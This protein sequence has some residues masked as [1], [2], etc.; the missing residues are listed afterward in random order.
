MRRSS[1]SMSGWPEARHAARQAAPSGASTSLGQNAPEEEDGL[2]ALAEDARERDKPNDPQTIV[3]PGLVDAVKG[4]VDS[5]TADIS[6]TVPFLVK[7]VA[8]RNGC[9]WISGV[10]AN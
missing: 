2:R 5:S 8:F 7:Q 4:L 10:T 3:S 9:F 6:G 1:R